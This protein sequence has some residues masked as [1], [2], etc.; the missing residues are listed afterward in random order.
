M[1]RHV[2]IVIPTIDEP[3]E[4]RECF[5]HLDQQT[6]D[7][8]EVL[9][10]DSGTGVNQTVVDEYSSRLD[11]EILSVPKNG[12]PRARNT[13]LTHL[14]GTDVVAFCDPDARPFPGWLEALTTAYDEGVGAVGGPVLEPGQSLQPRETVGE[15]CSNGEIV[16]NFD[17]EGRHR[18]QHLRGTNM[19]F[20]VDILR[21]LGGFDPAYRGTAHYED[22]DA[23]HKVYRAGYD[24]VYT[25]DAR[26]EH[27]HPSSER[28]LKAYHHYRLNNW[29]VLFEK[30]SPS[31]LDRLSFYIRLLVRT[32][33]YRFTL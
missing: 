32:A 6:Y 20:D 5:E 28:D 24:V 27:H 11:V 3:E 33:Y 12:L 29:P 21:E 16:S 23:T 1:I 31:T 22:T 18:V 17:A 10:V 15:I 4:L 26:L 30:T 13:A 8:F 2:S 9:V 7:P 19:S 14:E 25:P